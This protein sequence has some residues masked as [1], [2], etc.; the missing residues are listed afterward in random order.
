MT[1]EILVSLNPEKFSRSKKLR[2]NFVTG[3]RRTFYVGRKTRVCRSL[4]S[5]LLALELVIEADAAAMRRSA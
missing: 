4:I 3:H 5:G 1:N 2:I